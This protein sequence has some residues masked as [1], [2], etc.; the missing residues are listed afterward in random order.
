MILR[1]LVVLLVYFAGTFTTAEGKTWTVD[2]RQAKLM[3]GINAGQK[4]GEL[5][6]KEARSL[7]KMQAGI[8]RKKAKMK[9]ENLGRLTPEN[10]S[11]L[12]EEL[13][14]VSVELNRLRLE[15]RVTSAG[16]SK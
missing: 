11:E 12:E 9:G 5:T 15:K 8:A 2:D 10:T 3:Q 14:K 6:V 1:I 4:S 7:R 13:N 16:G